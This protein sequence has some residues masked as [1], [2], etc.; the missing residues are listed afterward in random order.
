MQLCE[1]DGR[2]KDH[3]VAGMISD[4]G[5]FAARRAVLPRGFGTDILKLVFKL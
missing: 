2:I 5:D 3:Y 4:F 1:Y